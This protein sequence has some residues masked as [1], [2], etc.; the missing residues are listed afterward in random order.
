MLTTF[1]LGGALYPLLELSWR[2]RTH[3]SMALAG[4][5][6]LCLLRLIDRRLGAKPLALQ[7]LLGG[8]G[9]TAIELATGLAFNRRHSVWDYRKQPLQ[10]RGQICAAFT[11]A[12]CALSALALG[13][14][15]AVK[16]ARS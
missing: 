10:F 13:G 3:V 16:R 7:A 14:M 12:W 1:L 8:L 11:L 9:I 2:G 4:G 5:A 15:R 6:S